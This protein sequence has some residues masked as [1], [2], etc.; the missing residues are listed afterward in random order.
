MMPGMS[1]LSAGLATAFHA[2]P[3]HPLLTREAVGGRRFRRGRGILLPQR[4]LPLQTINLARLVGD[5]F[6]KTFVLAAQALDLRNGI[7]PRLD[8]RSGR[9]R[10]GVPSLS[11][12]P[13]HPREG[14]ES[15]GEVQEA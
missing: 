14:T 10:A 5:L 11:P 3:A 9:S 7:T 8:N 12:T 15:C 2:P 6:S 13:L 4:E 1:G